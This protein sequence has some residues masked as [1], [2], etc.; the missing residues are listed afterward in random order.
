MYQLG[1]IKCKSSQDCDGGGTHTIT[2]YKKGKVAFSNTHYG[3]GG[4]CSGFYELLQFLNEYK[5]GKTK[6]I[7]AV[8]FDSIVNRHR[9]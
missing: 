3:C 7:I 2:G 6:K 1:V 5:L 9:I 4:E 8:A